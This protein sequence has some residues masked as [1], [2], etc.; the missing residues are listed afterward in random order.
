MLGKVM[1]IIIF[2]V[3]AI[4]LSLIQMLPSQINLSLYERVVL[5]PL[6]V[7]GPFQHSVF[8]LHMS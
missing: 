2:Q 7:P 3:L 6:I 8:L 5:F 1:C 4:E